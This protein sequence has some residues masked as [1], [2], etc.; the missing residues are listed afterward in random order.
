MQILGQGQYK[1]MPVEDQVL[2]LYVAVQNHLA[3][4]DVSAVRRFE[5]EWL[6]YLH[7]V[8]VDLVDELRT[9]HELT[10]ELRAKLDGAVAEFKKRFGG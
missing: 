8:R 9:R 1:P 2:S 4:V 10:P 6:R 5:D 7:D 3:D